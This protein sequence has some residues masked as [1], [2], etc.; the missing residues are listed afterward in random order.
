MRS[1]TG[2]RWPK[3]AQEGGRLAIPIAAGFGTPVAATSL[4]RLK[5]YGAAQKLAFLL[6]A[7]VCPLLGQVS[8]GPLS[9]AHRS[10][11]GTLKCASCHVFGAG[12]PKLKCLDCHTEIRALVRQHESY[13]GRVV[14]RAKGDM[15]CVRCHTEHYGEDFRIYKWE[16]SKEEFDH[17]QAGYPLV[18]RLAEDDLARLGPDRPRDAALRSGVDRLRR[19]E[20]QLEDHLAPFTALDREQP[21]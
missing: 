12:S 17:R 18:G 16:T 15:D 2:G 14:D 4:L 10:L 21:A 11:D 20:G 19:R 8:P 9:K 6:L 1:W 13:H 5:V 7:A 3:A